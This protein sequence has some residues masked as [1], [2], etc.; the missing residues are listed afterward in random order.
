[1]GID[2]RNLEGRVAKQLANRVDVPSFH[3]KFTGE[4]VTYVVPPE[5][6]DSDGEGFNLEMPVSRSA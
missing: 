6:C 1:M 4:I 3:H 2:E 5:V